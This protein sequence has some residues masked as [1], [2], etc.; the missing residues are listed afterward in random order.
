MEAVEEGLNGRARKGPP[1][2]QLGVTVAAEL[3][4]WWQTKLMVPEY[5]LWL[6]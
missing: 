4:L 6:G 1:S 3:V 2:C 5:R